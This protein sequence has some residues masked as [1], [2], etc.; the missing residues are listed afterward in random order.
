MITVQDSLYTLSTKHT[1]Y[2]FHVM[3]S[4]HLEHLYYGQRIDRGNI[5]AMKLKRAFEPGNV[6]NY[7][8]DHVLVLED[9]R[10]EISSYGKGDIREP[11]IEVVYPDGS[12]T[13]DFRFD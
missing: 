7:V 1:T 6:I 10:L 4:G 5:E 11:F 8:P 3:S 13:S 12:Y 9:R 2:S